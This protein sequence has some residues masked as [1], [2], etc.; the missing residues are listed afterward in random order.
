MTYSVLA[1]IL[2]GQG[3][4]SENAFFRVIYVPKRTP[5]LQVIEAGILCIMFIIR[6]Y[7]YYI[8]YILYNKMFYKSS[9]KTNLI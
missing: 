6:I 4:N 7:Y 2:S 1:S 9:G 3:A 5:H 8:K